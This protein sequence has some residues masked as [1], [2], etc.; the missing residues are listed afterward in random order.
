MP[1]EPLKTNFRK[2]V[3]NDSYPVTYVRIL[4]SFGIERSKKS[5]M[6]DFLPGLIEI[7]SIF[8]WVSG[9]NMLRNDFPT[10]TKIFTYSLFHFWIWGP[11][12][13]KTVYFQSFEM[14]IW[15]SYGGS[16]KPPQTVHFDPRPY[17]LELTLEKKS[18]FQHRVSLIRVKLPRFARRI[19]I[20]EIKSCLIVFAFFVRNPF[21]TTNHHF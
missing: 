12:F 8:C 3:G 21:P 7:T 2:P 13:L 10:C 17:T 9:P 4:G 6:T 1:L 11:F 20:K 18:I 5:D 15:M 19:G 16:L 14:F